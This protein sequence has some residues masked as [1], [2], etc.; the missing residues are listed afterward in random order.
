VAP[1]RTANDRDGRVRLLP[2]ALIIALLAGCLAAAAVD[3]HAQGGGAGRASAAQKPTSVVVS[4]S[5]LPPSVAGSVVVRGPR[6]LKVLKRSRTLRHVRPGRFTFSV[7]QVR[8]AA[9]RGSVRAG[10]LAL[11]AKRS[12]RVLVKPGRVTRVVL[13]YGTIVNANAR[14][15]T[16]SPSSVQGAARNP[17]GLTLAP[18]VRATVG[19]ILTARP[20]AK[21]PA[22]L[23]HRVTAARR[24]GR[25]T[26]VKLKPAGLDEAF[27]Q[28]DLD[29]KVQ[30]APGRVV[31][32]QVRAAGFDPLVAS[33]GIDKF[34]CQ[35]P[36]ADSHLTVGHRFDVDADVELHIPKRFGIPVGLPNGK[37]ALTLTGSA[38][39][40]S[41]F[42][43]NIGCSAQVTLPPLRG[44]I[45]VG[46]VVVPVYA[47]VG[48]QG[49]ATLDSDLRQQASVNFT[50]RGGMTFRGTHAD[51]ISTA[52]A[53]ASASAS[54]SGK[55]AVGPTIRF[56]VGVWE[57]ADVH[58]DLQPS[59]AFTAA[60]DHSCSLD[61]VGDSQAGI[62][63]GPFELNQQLPAPKKNLYRCPAGPPQLAITQSAPFGAFLNQAFDY[64]IR[65]TN[66]G[67]SA[68]NGVE[69]VSTLPGAGTFVSSSPAGSPAAPAAGTAHTVALGTLAAGETKTVTVRWR[70]PG[71]ET[72][73]T[74]SAVVRA[75]NAAQAGPATAAVPVGTTA[76]CN[77]C[78]AESAGTG[79]RNRDHGAITIS[80]IPVGATVG[81][82]VLVWGILY[83]TD[84]PA[85]TITFDGHPVAAD[86]TQSTSGNLCW[87]DTDTVG[88]AADV[89]SYVTGNGTF[90]ITDPPRG[91]TRVD[92][93]PA[94]TLPY[95]DGAT[96][97]VF[98]NGGGAQN[99]VLS[100]FAYDTNTDS[101]GAIER[102]FSDIHSVGGAAW[103]T[104][105]GPDGQT[106][107]GETITLSGD[108]DEQRV[109]TWD[110]SD[111]QDG[112]SFDIGNLWDTDR[113]DV[114]AI[115][116]AGQPT[117]NV[118]HSF[119]TDCIGV[120]A[121]VLQVSQ[122]P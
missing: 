7:R 121:A 51:N 99:Q 50:L 67:A 47:Q 65:V 111:P 94:G 14:R 122:I 93:D 39:L 60:L 117:L 76:N 66:T 23:F 89:T 8:I 105:A 21:L 32:G 11:P 48:L 26:I 85:D 52:S 72:T 3:A 63:I 30:F 40:D 81:R 31:T 75:S 46:P 9:R 73:V 2:A 101:D 84:V 59:L 53:G 106:N 12:V 78:G 22:G 41:L 116:P 74:N 45:P 36:L 91:T 43:K 27:P 55:L 102:S 87:G 61:L 83:D 86:V 16:L 44:A 56:A 5:G 79:L 38:S 18:G 95:T 71:S 118:S 97:V 1:F 17:S 58:L 88:Y 6:L 108:G 37:L 4:V 64:T 98:Y 25:R 119:D 28:L 68:A 15:L 62:S 33:L 110:G 54:G 104:L 49:Q 96:L 82:A 112:P 113:Y 120:G 20:S 34:R 29:A 70:A 80:G 107:F 57:V 19:T 109:D 10:S 92:S 69:V 77:P 114:S 42:R 115:V 90:E 100:D 103:L 35:L 24:A 13:K